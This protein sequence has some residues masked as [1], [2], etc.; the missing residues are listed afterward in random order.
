MAL[1]DANKTTY[2]L[3]SGHS[4]QLDKAIEEVVCQKVQTLIETPVTE[5]IYTIDGVSLLD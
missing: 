2:R 3:E 4:S 5:D 1:N